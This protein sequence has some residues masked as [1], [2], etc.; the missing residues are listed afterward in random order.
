M[1]EPQL[2]CPRCR[3]QMERGYVMDRGHYS[4]GNIPNWVEG[5]PERSVWSGLHT[6]G[7]DVI[8]V[9][10]YRCERCGFLESYARA[11]EG[12]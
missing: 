6:K 12:G 2:E 5:V 1:A 8:P 4:A 9:A 10:T 7:R 3:G 11:T